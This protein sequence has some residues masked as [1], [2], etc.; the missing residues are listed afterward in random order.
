MKYLP[1]SDLLVLRGGHV[2]LSQAIQ[3]GKPTVTVPIDNHG[4]QLGNSTKISE[5]RSRSCAASKVIETRT[6]GEAIEKAFGNP[7][8]KK[9]AGELQRLAETL[10][11][12]DN[13]VQIVRSY[14]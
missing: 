13:V 1:Y 3:F 7:H 5:A 9:K 6:A 12:I 14:L 11:G 8:Y 2:A 4:E 10:N